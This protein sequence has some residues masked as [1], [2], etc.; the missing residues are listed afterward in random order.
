MKSAG[1]RKKNRLRRALVW[2]VVLLVISTLLISLPA[3][4]LNIISVNELSNISEDE[5]A[6]ASGL[7]EGQHLAAGLGGSLRHFFQLRYGKAEQKIADSLP[8]VRSAIVKMRFPS[9]IDIKIDERIEVAYVT[10]PDG[11]VLID[12]EGYALSIHSELPDNIP[13]IAGIRAVSLSL[14]QP[15]T[16]D[17]TSSMQLAVSIMG[18]IIDA[19]RDERSTISLI[20]QV[21]KIRPAGGDLVYLTVVLPDTGEELIILAE[22]AGDL[23]DDMLWLR[24]AIE[25]NVLSGHGRGILDL[26]GDKRIFRPDG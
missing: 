12:K 17:V 24:F 25:Q 4:H 9:Q 22:R 1:T 5:I 6:A 3:F 14:G 10:I 7:R 20:S 18:A 16:V 21:R 19:D 23:A 11:C 13:V 2:L 15:L 26:T 8:Y